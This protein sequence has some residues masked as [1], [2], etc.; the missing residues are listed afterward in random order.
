MEMA[1]I[2]E[3]A[4]QFVQKSCAGEL[5]RLFCMFIILESI[6]Q[7][8]RLNILD[9][10]KN[11]L[12][13]KHWPPQLTTTKKTHKQNTINYTLNYINLFLRLFFLSVFPCL[14]TRNKQ[15]NNLSFRTGIR[16]RLGYEPRKETLGYFPWNTGCLIGILVMVYYN[17][18]PITPACLY[19]YPKQPFFHYSHDDHE[20]YVCR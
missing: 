17:Y 18:N 3:Q 11:H 13:Q 12:Q 4:F 10:H 15:K 20:A 16:W 8:Y 7:M 1:C 19:N 5:F 2:I 6:S 14:S 9:F